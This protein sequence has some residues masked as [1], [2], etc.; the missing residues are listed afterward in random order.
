[1]WIQKVGLKG[2]E[3]I[4]KL[5]TKERRHWPDGGWWGSQSLLSGPVS[6][7]PSRKG[8]MKPCS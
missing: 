8:E 2:S 4:I 1:M 3:Q 5:E 6:S 7:L